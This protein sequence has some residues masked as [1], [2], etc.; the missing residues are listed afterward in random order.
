MVQNLASVQEGLNVPYNEGIIFDDS[1]GFLQPKVCQTL[2]LS[3]LWL[4]L[5]KKGICYAKNRK[6]EVCIQSTT[7]YSEAFGKKKFFVSF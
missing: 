7:E 3:K 5:K 1:E 6:N 4:E 2:I